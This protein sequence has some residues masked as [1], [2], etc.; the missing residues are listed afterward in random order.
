MNKRDL[1]A[2]S[3]SGTYCHKTSTRPPSCAKPWQPTIYDVTQGEHFCDTI[4]G[5][6]YKMHKTTSFF[7]L[8]GWVGGG[9]KLGK[10]VLSN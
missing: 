9:Q 5:C 4:S 6:Y 3:L 10:I 2:L 7:P 8:W 1:Q